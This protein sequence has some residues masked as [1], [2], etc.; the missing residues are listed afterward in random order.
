MVMNYVAHIWAHDDSDTSII[1]CMG[2]LGA[3]DDKTKLGF[4]QQLLIK[5]IDGSGDWI[6]LDS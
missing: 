3:N 1:K 5:R 6:V 2:Y 4:E